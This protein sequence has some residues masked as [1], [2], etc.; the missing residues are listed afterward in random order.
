MKE[1]MENSQNPVLRKATA[2]TDNLAN[3]RWE[4]AVLKTRLYDADFD[5]E[6]LSF[7]SEEIFKEFFCNYLAGNQQYLD[8]VC[9]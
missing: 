5:L 1:Q 2:I 4:K 7:E 8:L 3:K 6:Q 9:G